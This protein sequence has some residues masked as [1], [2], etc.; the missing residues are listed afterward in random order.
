[1]RSSRGSPATAAKRPARRR[2]AASIRMIRRGATPPVHKTV[3]EKAWQPIVNRPW[4]AG[5]FV[6][7]GF[8]YRGEPTP[9]QWPCVGAHYGI[10]DICGFPK[11]SY[12]YY[13]GRMGR[14]TRGA[15]LPAVEPRGSGKT[16]GSRL[17]GKQCGEVRVVPEW[18]EPGHPRDAR[19][20][21]SRVAGRLCAGYIGGARIRRGRKDGRHRQTGNHRR[22]LRAWRSYP[23]VL[24]FSPTAKMWSSRVATCSM[25]RAGSCPWRTMRSRSP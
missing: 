13:L 24:R 2:P 12:Y 5:G 18:H 8:D 3:A 6:W 20:W 23:T 9:Y 4:M 15:H 16:A 25:R 11:D 22:N 10:M 21:A 19:A 17:G 14:Q 1:M 7:T